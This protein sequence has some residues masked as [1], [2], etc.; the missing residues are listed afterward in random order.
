MDFHFSLN[1]T[2][3]PCSSRCIAV[4]IC[5]SL[6]W[7]WLDTATEIPCAVYAYVFL[8]LVDIWLLSCLGLCH[9]LGLLPQS[10]HNVV[11]VTRVLFTDPTAFTYS[12]YFS[13]SSLV[14]LSFLPAKCLNTWLR[15][16]NAAFIF[17]CCLVVDYYSF[18]WI[19]LILLLCISEF[20]HWL[21]SKCVLHCMCVIGSLFNILGGLFTTHESPKFKIIYTKYRFTYSIVYDCL[22]DMWCC[23]TVE[24]PLKCSGVKWSI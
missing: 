24:T 11:L 12:R 10:V 19:L 4:E 23:V 20:W 13:V 5:L 21:G 7:L 16:M 18:L 14:Q 1:A 8:L 3:S 15:V 22:Y 9:L 6:K 2:M 17:N